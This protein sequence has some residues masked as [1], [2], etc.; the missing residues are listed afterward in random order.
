MNRIIDTINKDGIEFKHFTFHSI[1][2]T[3]ASRCLEKGMTPKVLQTI[4][5]HS[6]LSTTMD[7]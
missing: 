3:M 1:R 6:K 4:L 5:G 2:H 7:L